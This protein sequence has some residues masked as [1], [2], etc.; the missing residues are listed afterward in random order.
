[1]A[2][3]RFYADRHLLL[4]FKLKFKVINTYIVLKSFRA[5]HQFKNLPCT[6]LDL[7]KTADQWQTV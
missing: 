2:G 4:T 7:K 6:L 5:I 3:D 1:M